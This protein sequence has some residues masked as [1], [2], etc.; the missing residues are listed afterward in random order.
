MIIISEGG[1]H[2]KH[3]HYLSHMILFLYI[4]RRALMENKELQD[5][6]YENL[7]TRQEAMK[8]TKQSKPAFDQSIRTGL[9]QPFF[10]KGEQRQMI[11]LYLKQDIEAYA[12]RIAERQAKSRN[13]KN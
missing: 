13:S 8:I 6:M 1:R 12:A 4:E 3:L 5:W 7:L 9:I 11:R 2:S 10:P